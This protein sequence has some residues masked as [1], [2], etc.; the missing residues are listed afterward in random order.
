MEPSEIANK[1]KSTERTYGFVKGKSGNPNGRPKK[2][3]EEWEL[4][5][6]C[7][8]KA[9]QALDVMVRIMESGENERNQLAAANS[10]IE[11]AYGKPIQ[12]T[13]IQLAGQVEI[14]EIV[15]KIVGSSDT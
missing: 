3:A 2:T 4:I 8:A 9:P 5:A 15:R 1:P 10:I 6:A 12:P 13:D 11:R 7:R 14:R